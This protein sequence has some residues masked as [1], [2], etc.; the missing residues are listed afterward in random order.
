MQIVLSAARA[1]HMYSWRRR[2]GGPQRRHLS[3]GPRSC[4]KSPGERRA[5]AGGAAADG[6]VIM[7]THAR[8]RPSLRPDSARLL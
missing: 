3:A 8:S 7:C 6:G 1:P 2:E 5:Y 4:V